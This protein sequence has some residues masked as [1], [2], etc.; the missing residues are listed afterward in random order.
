MGTVSG[1]F[2]IEDITPSVGGGRYAAKAVVGEDVPIGAVSYREGHDALGVSVAW[3]GPGGDRTP[4]RAR[5]GA[6]GTDRWQAV[7]RP[8]APGAHE[9]AIEAWSDPYATWH[10][11]VLVKIEAGQGAVDLANDLAKGAAI[12]D[13]AVKGAPSEY[14]EALAAAAD[15]LRDE[16]ASL[17]DRIEPALELAQV[18][19][20][21]PVRELVTTSEW[22]PLWVD[23]ERALFSAWYELFPRSEGKRRADG[24]IT[25]GTFASAAARLPKIAEMGFDIVYLPPIHPIGEVNRK[26]RN[27]TLRALP[28]D[29]G[30]PWAIGSADGGHDAI[31]PQ[32]GTL[33]DFKKF[34]KAARKNGLEVALDLALQCAPDHPWVTAHP[35]WFTTLADGSI[36]FAENPPKK[37][38]DIYPLNF[39]NDPEGIRAEI[40]RVVRH[41]IAAGVKVFRV[42]NPHTKPV[43][44][45]HWLIAEVKKTDPDVLFLAEAF[46]RPA[47]MIGLGSIGFSQSYTYFTWRNT[48]AEL[49]EYCEQLIATADRMRPNFWPT[50]PD[51]MPEVLQNGLPPMFRIRAILAAMLSPSWGIYSGYELFE[52]VPRP[53]VEELLDSS[54]PE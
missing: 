2:P 47:M 43:E 15:A 30:S 54:Y 11:A 4:V 42:D 5:P 53:G 51:I 17:S 39:D 52:H 26:G 33:A 12:F 44:F 28:T 20:D 46:T 1:R 19:W 3:R 41:W 29:V 14:A 8:D 21:Y 23:R 10:H 22:L 34:V 27:N 48:P 32:L 24:T 45:W 7:L 6:P 31:H 16:N 50:T 35:E 9:F 38:Q 13:L 49:R 25:H 40:L 36:A 18:M 37:Y